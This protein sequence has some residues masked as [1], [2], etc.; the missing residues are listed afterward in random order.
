MLSAVL[1]GIPYKTLPRIDLG[2]FPIQTFGLMVAIGVL[3][4]IWFGADHGERY[5]VHRD[6]A[7]RLGTRM[8][9][10]GVIGARITWVATHWD[11][12]ENPIDVIAVWEGGLQFSGG[13]I[14]AI[15]VGLPTFLSW[16]RLQRWQL[17]DGYAVAVLI[18]AG[19]GRIGCLSVGEHFGGETTF[20]L[21]TRF[22]GTL[23]SDPT[24][25][26]VRE[27]TLGLEP[28]S[29][30]VVEGMTFHNPAL[31]EMVTAFVLFGILWWLLRKRLTPGTVGALFL[32]G[33]S[34]Q[35]FAYDSLRVNDERVMGMTG[36]QWM[37][38]AMIPIGFYVW[39]KV[40]PANAAALAAGE[41]GGQPV[42]ETTVHETRSGG[43]IATT[44]R[45][46]ASSR[47][48]HATTRTVAE[49]GDD[50]GASG[51][52]PGEGPDPTDEP[53][54]RGET[55][56]TNETGETDEPDHDPRSG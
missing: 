8:V 42:T 13:F 45:R 36:A 12:I 55:D 30:R 3:L 9:L 20:P 28:D 50:G 1:G 22:E 25:Q 6:D 49:A 54:E 32:F 16:N 39:F 11:Q 43:S 7:Y 37:C 27:L 56:P 24:V 46:A 35:R 51:D 15:A 4:A 34:V 14:A 5:G 33:Y 47:P 52:A 44:K 19:F 23:T 31:Y 41:V 48:S 26:P 21:A 40:R 10:A 53:A 38:L 18:G 17:L 2:P 29:P